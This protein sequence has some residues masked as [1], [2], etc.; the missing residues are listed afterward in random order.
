MKKYNCPDCFIKT[1][2][3]NGC[4]R[5]YGTN[6]YGG[7][8]LDWS[9]LNINTYTATIPEPCRHCAAHPSNGGDG[10]CWCILGSMNITC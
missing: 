6:T 4:P 3:C 7:L 10:I 5:I 8:N 9:K 1:D 2:S